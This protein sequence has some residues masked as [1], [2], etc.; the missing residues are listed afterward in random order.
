MIQT[1]ISASL[2]YPHTRPMARAH[3]W[4][5]AAATRVRCDEAKASHWGSAPP[6]T[7][8]TIRGVRAERKT[9]MSAVEEADGRERRAGRQMHLQTQP[10]QVRCHVKMRQIFREMTRK[11]RGASTPA[12]LSGQKRR[13]GAPRAEWPSCTGCL[14]NKESRHFWC[15]GGKAQHDGTSLS[16]RGAGDAMLWR[17][18]L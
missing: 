6:A 3:F 16:A 14:P 17:A 2:S 11:C 13:M 5:D 1:C 8:G 10:I 18:R 9:E 12:T 15:V 7:T 4:G